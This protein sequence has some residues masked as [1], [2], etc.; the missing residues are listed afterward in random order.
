MH[1]PFYK[2][3]YTGEYY[4]PWVRL[5]S[6]KDYYGMAA[7]ALEREDVRLSFNMVPSL[8][9]QVSDYAEGRARDRNMDLSLRDPKDLEEGD[10]E[11][12][13]SNFFRCF[14]PT[15]IDPYP[16][17]RELLQKMAKDPAARRK[18]RYPASDLRDLQVWANLAW[19][20]RTLRESDPVVKGLID[21]GRDFTEADKA[22]LFD[23]QREIVARVIP[24]YRRL[25]EEGRAELSTSPFYHPILPLLCRMESA[26]EAMPN[27]RLPVHRGPYTRDAARHVS[28]AAAFHEKIF[29]RRPR[30]LWPPEGSVS[31]DI[32]PILSD[33]GLT[34]IAT[35]EGILESSL[36]R[37]FSDCNGDSAVNAGLYT[38][39]RLRAPDAPLS[40]FF[41]DRALSDL[42]GF[43]YYGM[44]PAAA[45][46]D[47]T[48]KLLKIEAKAQGPNPIVTIILDGENPWEHYPDG[49][50]T[51]LR[52]LYASIAAQP[53]LK[54]TTFS[55]HLKWRNSTPVL[56]RLGAGS[57]INAN[58]GIWIGSPQDNAAWDYLGRTRQHLASAEHKGDVDMAWESVYAAEGSDW[59][60]WYGDDFFSEEK[61][62]FDFIFRKNLKNA[63]RFLS[64]EVPHFLEEAIFSDPRATYT[65][66]SGL[67]TAVIDGCA[68]NFFEWSASGKY[69]PSA[70]NTT[71]GR[72]AGRIVKEILFGFSMDS[73][74]LRIDTQG[75]AADK[76][77]GDR[78]VR[79]EFP[80]AG[81][82]VLWSPGGNGAVYD[83]GRGAACQP[84]DCAC[85]RKVLEMEVPFAR[86]GLERGSAISFSV[87]IV[88]KGAT[89]ERHPRHGHF[90]F[91]AP[92]EDFE[93]E[94]WQ[95]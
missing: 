51:F 76:L 40:A 16:R 89:I 82:S 21:K 95:V 80:R 43:A 78:H 22:A 35:D 70:E 64:E 94:N 60:W 2:D 30:G 31:E 20:H 85:A 3:M 50:V 42:I 71:M 90:E 33:E 46:A 67:M 25:E 57:W 24:M 63:F 62:Q 81:K 32:L 56:P 93:M 86:I 87:E 74:F 4:L 48:S 5:H 29:G 37:S 18:R 9:L 65:R 10:V 47:F 66:P 7:L 11:F 39:Y 55:G 53:K 54:M 15:M 58:F 91:P 49:G 1:Q 12:I 13:V 14:H 44:D 59:F 77:A 83:G 75:S 79:V 69:A 23:K 34:W 28:K 27:A 52:S 92:T 68:T 6:I 72:T 41:R 19:F 26:L 61:D 88:E 38:P 8:M 45:A 17:Y 73:L 36:L 84:F